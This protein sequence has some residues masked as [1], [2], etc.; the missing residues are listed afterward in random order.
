M[1]QLEE[2]V[3]LQV[4]P[5]V[6]LWPEPAWFPGLDP[7]SPFLCVAHAG[8][9][10]VVRISATF[11]CVRTYAYVIPSARGWCLPA[12][13][14]SAVHV[15]CLG[16]VPVSLSAAPHSVLVFLPQVVTR[17]HLWF[18]CVPRLHCGPGREGPHPLLVARS[19]TTRITL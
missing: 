6:H 11:L 3:E 19:I 8:F 14:V 5:C 18:L 1:S 2:V 12:F 9:L 4:G 17:V 13:Q 16:S 15:T 7:H 10:A